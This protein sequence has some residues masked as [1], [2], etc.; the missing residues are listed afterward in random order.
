MSGPEQPVEEPVG[1]V[2]EPT[3]RVARL[4]AAW[5]RANPYVGVGAFFGGFVWDA[6]TLVRVD[7]LFDNLYLATCLFL[8][9][10]SLVIEHRVEARPEHRPWLT[11]RVSWVSYLAQFLFGS[12]FSAYVVFYFRS[13]ATRWHLLFVLMLAGAMVFNEFLHGY[14]RAERLRVLL[15]GFSTFT[16]LLFFI[17]VVTGW[18]GSGLFLVAAL[19][20]FAISGLLVLAMHAGLS[21]EG[22]RGA[23]YSHTAGLAG[24]LF[25]L[26]LADLT[27]VI[28][29]IPVA[30]LEHGV[31]HK[32][33]VREE[34]DPSGERRDRRYVLSYEDRGLVSWFQH[35]DA[36]FNLREGDRAHYFTAIFTPSGTVI[37]V[38]HR[39]E[40]WERD[41]WVT[42]DVID[43]STRGGVTGGAASGFRTW[44][45]KQRMTP[46]PWRVVAETRAGRVLSVQAF[47]VVQGEDGA[48]VLIERAYD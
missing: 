31:F 24:L 27:G 9:G 6:L 20:T 42:T 11:A 26:G 44:S 29:P 8:L 48:A 5:D 4:R 23:V 3:G 14:L 41:G 25:L 1:G 40:R 37:D 13:A 21:E 16:F 36:V 7:R 43:V 15:F 35:H 30:V 39:W 33:E 46:G 2:D 32:V 17:P 10:V 47:E 45:A 28:P 34:P 12:L 22:P 38:V 19:L 18:L